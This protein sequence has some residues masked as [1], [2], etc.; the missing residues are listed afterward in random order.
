MLILGVRNKVEHIPFLSIAQYRNV[1]RTVKDRAAFENVPLPTITFVGTV[2][3]HGT[4]ASVAWTEDGEMFTQ[5]RSQIITPENDNAGFAKY[6]K[7]NKELFD[8]LTKPGRVIFGEWCGG[9]I[10]S[11]V[12]LNQLPKMFVVFAIKDGEEWL[13]WNLIGTELGGFS[14]GGK[15]LLPTVYDCGVNFI[16]IDFSQPEEF[17]NTLAELTQNVEKEC[18]FAKSLGVSGVG[19]GVVWTAIPHPTFNTSEL[20]FKVKGEKHSESKVKT[21]APVD[22]EK[23]HSI[24]ALVE[25]I[26]TVNRLE[27]CIEKMKVNGFEPVLQNT[28]QFLKTISLDVL[29]EEKDTIDV[30]G[31][32]LQ[33][34]MKKVSSV[35]KQFYMKKVS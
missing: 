32:P 29:K 28:G 14:V 24:N 20:R 33:D 11:G 30:S 23:I 6:V 4:N 7:D 19:E 35:A 27:Q 3:L 26:V 34:V 18:P 17:Q 31:L 10:Q 16:A 13:K 21:L 2:K 15:A 22:V 1:I 8:Q 12:A 25:A 5:S 9:N